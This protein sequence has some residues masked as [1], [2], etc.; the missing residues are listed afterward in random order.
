MRHCKIF[1]KKAMIKILLKK[2][3]DTRTFGN[4]TKHSERE[5]QNIQNIKYKCQPY[6]RKVGLATLWQGEIVPGN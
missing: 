1:D 2:L 4:Y 5:I 6:C 3:F